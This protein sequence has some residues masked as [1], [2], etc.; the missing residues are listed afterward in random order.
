MF[1]L[2]TNQCSHTKDGVANLL[3]TLDAC[4]SNY[5]LYFNTD[6]ITD[7]RFTLSAVLEY[8]S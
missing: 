3:L 4:V 7:P 8:C 5:T 6:I 1:Y 2:F